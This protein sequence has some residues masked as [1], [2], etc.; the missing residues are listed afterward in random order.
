MNETAET[1]RHLISQ[2]MTLYQAEV[3]LCLEKGWT[4]KNSR[5]IW[6]KYIRDKERNRNKTHAEIV[7]RW[8]S[9]GFCKI[10]MVA[11]LMGVSEFMATEATTR[12]LKKPD[13]SM[14]LKSKV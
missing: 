6:R 12:Y 3:S 8:A 1:I 9:L 5:D 13:H 4:R 10:S 2:G 14:I 7:E 11:K